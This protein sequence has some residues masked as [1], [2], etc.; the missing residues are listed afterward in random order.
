MSASIT[1]PIWPI[2]VIGGLA[3]WALLDRLLMPSMRWW[4]KSRA[5]RVLDEVGHRL[6][7]GIRPFQQVKR[8][9]LILETAVGCARVGY[10][11]G[12]WRGRSR[13]F[14]QQAAPQAFGRRISPAVSLATH[15]TEH[16]VAGKRGLERVA[17]Q[18][19]L[20]RSE[21]K[22]NPGVG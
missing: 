16:A 2:I 6:K 14:G 8:Q 4:V 13:E 9:A 15:R 20:P 21:W 7:I 5:N 10:A 19:W 12:R 18:H 3:A 17:V 22:I 1:L 11:A